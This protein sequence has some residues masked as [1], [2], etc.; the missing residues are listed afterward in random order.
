MGQTTIHCCNTHPDPL[1]PQPCD[2]PPLE[3]PNHHMV[4]SH[5]TEGR[6][7][8]Q[9]R[10]HRWAGAGLRGPGRAMLPAPACTHRGHISFP[11]AGSHGTLSTPFPL[12]G[13]LLLREV[14][15][16]KQEVEGARP[17]GAS[18]QVR[19]METSA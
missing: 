11:L 1:G 4:A 18:S 14:A 17:R 8:P 15:A 13:G 2:R 12:G 16:K 6:R 7:S 19:L 10:A 3:H 9:T 5:P